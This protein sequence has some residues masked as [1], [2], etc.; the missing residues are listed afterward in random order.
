[1]ANEES[2]IDKASFTPDAM[3]AQLMKEAGALPGGDPETPND[4]AETE[5]LPIAANQEPLHRGFLGDIKTPEEMRAYVKNLEDTVVR[6]AAGAGVAPTI[7]PAAPIPGPT[8]DEQIDAVWFSDP[9]KARELMKQKDKIERDA[10]A[11]AVRTRE[12][13]Y[14]RFYQ[15]NPDLKRVERIVQSI[16]EQKGQQIALLRTE[17]EVA[18]FISREAREQVDYF[19]RAIP[20]NE[21]RLESKPAVT[22]GASGETPAAPPIVVQKNLTFID[23]IRQ[24]QRRSGGKK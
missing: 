17:A 13:F 20:G 15:K 7:T 23:Q 24:G 4:P 2:A 14:Q 5:D 18:D 6:Q 11:S 21:T 22:L 1:M 16:V 19:K 3:E 9:A 8:L 10:E 12:V